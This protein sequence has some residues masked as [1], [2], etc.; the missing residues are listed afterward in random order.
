MKRLIQCNAASRLLRFAILGIMLNAVPSTFL[1]AQDIEKEPAKTSE[2]PVQITV[3]HLKNI[4]AGETQKVI[5]VLLGDASGFRCIAEGKNRLLVVARP[6]QLATVQGILKEVDRLPD[7]EALIK[8]FALQYTDSATA[9]Q[10]LQQLI[11]DVTIAVDAR[12]NSIVTTGSAS[13]L[14]VIEAILQRLD[15]QQG[16]P[17][18]DHVQPIASYRFELFWLIEIFDGDD[19]DATRLRKPD[20]RIGE[21]VAELERQGF[22]EVRQVGHVRVVVKSGGQFRVQS[23]ASL[24]QLEVQ[25]E[26]KQT[27]EKRL[28]VLLDIRISQ[29][30]SVIA[31][32][33]TEITTQPDHNVVI[34]IAGATP[35]QPERRSAFVIRVAK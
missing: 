21:A 9:A 30:N 6:K 10:L 23:A 2:E 5:E 3:F 19:Q 27:Q 13:D 15:V 14:A 33:S 32:L 11:G 1:Q 29:E 17:R 7:D 25:G 18:A 20:Q 28:E 22:S 31:S 12:S 8:I 34:G 4:D 26:L 24:G 16:D 35:D